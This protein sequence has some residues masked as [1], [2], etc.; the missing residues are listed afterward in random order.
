MFNTY[1]YTLFAPDNNAMQ[2]AYAK[3]L[4]KWADIQELFE[5]Y[6]E[7]DDNHTVTPQ[8]EADKAMAYLKIKALRDFVRYHFMTNSVYAD[9]SIDAGRYSTLSA[10]EMGIAK[11]VVLSGGGGQ[12]S[13]ADLAGHSV[14]ISNAGGKLANKMARDYWFNSN[15]LRASSIV[16]SS[17][18]AVHQISEPLYG[19]TSG[20]FDEAWAN[21]AAFDRAVKAYKQRKVKNEL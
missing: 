9:N 16:T 12:L 14:T 10:D 15:K 2:S 13:V 19:E 7:L 4:P 5:K 17:F 6:A 11:E 20:R 3:G 8:E 21:K 1:N 18:C